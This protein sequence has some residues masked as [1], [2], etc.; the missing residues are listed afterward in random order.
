MLLIS[1]GITITIVLLLLWL[2]FPWKSQRF[3]RQFT[4][5]Q[6]LSLN[7]SLPRLSVITEH[8][9]VQVPDVPPAGPVLPLPGVLLQ[10][11]GL[12]VDRLGSPEGGVGGGECWEVV[13]PPVGWRLTANVRLWR[14]EAAGP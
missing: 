8:P 5:I 3:C 13:V 2:H 4:R 14:Y 9:G 10:L 1:P 7:T 12:T 11:P 6:V